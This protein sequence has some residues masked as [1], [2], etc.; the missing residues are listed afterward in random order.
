MNYKLI[1]VSLTLFV[2]MCAVPASSEHFTGGW[3]SAYD[4]SGFDEGR[5]VTHANNSIFVVGMSL[6][7]YNA[8]T[9]HL[10]KYDKDGT[11]LWDKKMPVKIWDRSYRNIAISS[12]NN[13]II[14]S[15]TD[16]TFYIARYDLDGNVLWNKKWG[17]EN[18]VTDIAVDGQGNIFVIGFSHEKDTEKFHV[19]K[20]GINGKTE[21]NTTLNGKGK[22][23]DTYNQSIFVAGCEGNESRLFKI[24]SNGNVVWERSYGTG[25]IKDVAVGD[26]I[27]L[28][29]SLNESIS[30]IKCDKEGNAIWSECY[31]KKSVAHSI[32][33]DRN[34]NAFIAGAA[35][36]LSSK[37]YDYLILKY[38][39]EGQ[40]IEER[41]YNGGLEEG[42]WD[43]AVNKS[44]VVTGYSVITKIIGIRSVIRDRDCYTIAYEME[45]VPPVANF[46]WNPKK[47]VAKKEV[48][49]TDMSYD[50]DGSIISWHWD[51][52]DNTVS[53]VREPTHTYKKD[54]FYSINLTVFDDGGAHH[55]IEKTL[56]VKEEE[57][58][59]GFEFAILLAAVSILLIKRKL[60]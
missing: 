19:L 34:E 2:I 58:I 55:S 12:Y 53:D 27:Y 18:S 47:P 30:L 24:D 3:E 37:D 4:L 22:G 56:E 43:L 50:V 1:L 40:L 41:G 54:G 7:T 28:L 23:I 6:D 8:C 57:G 46:S 44:I 29:Y 16:R 31:E 35:Y 33:M 36:N 32:I 45:N 15:Y 5:S 13:S 17:K 26:V 38:N 39:K 21:W 10:L 60:D 25:T 52:G 49:F 9:Y 14:L 48:K 42:G 20:Y 59:P 11:L 51:F